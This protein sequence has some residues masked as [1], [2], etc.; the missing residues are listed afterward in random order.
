V[1][2]VQPPVHVI[3]PLGEARVNRP[4][5]LS[6]KVGGCPGSHPRGGEKKHG[7]FFLGAAQLTQVNDPAKIPSGG[8]IPWGLLMLK[9]S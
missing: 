8:A 3:Q 5:W 6:S 7:A 9:V 2:V 4:A 1:N